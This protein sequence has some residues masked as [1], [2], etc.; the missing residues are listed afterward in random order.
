[1]TTRNYTLAAASAAAAMSFVLAAPAFAAD[2]TGATKA[3]IQ[4]RPRMPFVRAMQMGRHGVFGTVTAVSG[5]NITLTETDIRTKAVTTFTIDASGAKVL[6]DGTSST[7]AAITVGDSIMVEGTVTGTTVKATTIRDGKATERL[8]DKMEKH[9]DRPA[10]PPPP[11]VTGNGQPVVGGKITAI[12]GSSF[13]MTNSSNVAY[14][15]DA[16]AAV[17]AINNTKST[18]SA[19]TVGNSVVVQGAVNGSAITASSIRSS[20]VK[21]ATAGTSSHASAPRGFFGGI[22]AFFGK[23]FGF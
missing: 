1:M 11:V 17:V 9:G 8:G 21:P 12:N 7:V 18:L 22:G 20:G 6:K 13:T 2:V 3:N 15:V 19:L 5:N 16:S 4:L 10:T 14:T 23:L